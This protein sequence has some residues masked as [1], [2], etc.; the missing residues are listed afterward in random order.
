MYSSGVAK[1]STFLRFLCY[2]TGFD[3]CFSKCNVLPLDSIQKVILR[4][5][6]T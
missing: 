3:L 1:I 5:V 6:L 4:I 2:G